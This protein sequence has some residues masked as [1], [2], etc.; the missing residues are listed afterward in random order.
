MDPAPRTVRFAGLVTLLEAIA[1]LV[2]VA[3]LIVRA[4]TAQTASAG[5]LDPGSTY[6]EAGYF[7]VLSLGVLA[8]AVGLLRSKLWARTPVFLLQ[9]LLIGVGWYA[10]GPSGRPLLGFVFAVPAVFVIWCLFNR[11]GRAWWTGSGSAA[12]VDRRAG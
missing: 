10:I 12:D 5:S 8:A 6:G 11:A 4:G 1:G 2:F 7:G 9:L 3:A